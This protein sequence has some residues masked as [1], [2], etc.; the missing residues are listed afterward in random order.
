MCG[1]KLGLI[2]L[3][4]LSVPLSLWAQSSPSPQAPA[5]AFPPTSQAQEALWTSLLQRIRQ[6]PSQYDS[7]TQNLQTQINALQDNNLSLQTNVTSLQ[8]NN[9]QL[10]ASLS[11]SQ[12]REAT[13]ETQLQ[14]SQQALKNSTSSIIQA[15]N[16][17]RALEI[18]LDLW[19]GVGITFGVGFSVVAVYEGGKAAHWW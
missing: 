13:L 4:L 9:A 12:A 3:A 2:F 10:T 7:Y 11:Q 6:L 18:K 17:A 8:V 16:D 1:K 15:Q 5:S 19:K 14:Q